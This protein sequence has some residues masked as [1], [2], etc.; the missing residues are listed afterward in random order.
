MSPRREALPRLTD[1]DK[2]RIQGQDDETNLEQ[3]QAD[4]LMQIETEIK[5]LEGY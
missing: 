4:E 3:E 1:Y 5:N 2:G